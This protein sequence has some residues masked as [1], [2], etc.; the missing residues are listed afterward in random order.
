[1]FT[2]ILLALFTPVLLFAATAPMD[3]MAALNLLAYGGI[4]QMK[5]KIGGEPGGQAVNLDDSQWQIAYPGFQWNYPGTNIWL[6][7]HIAIPEKIG[8]FSLIGRKM[9]MYLYVDNGGDVFVNGDSLGTFKW[10]TATYT[11]SESL[12]PG[13]KFLIAIRGINGPGFGKIYDARIEF[14]GMVDFQRKLQDKVWG[15]LIARRLADQLSEK[16]S[17][18]MEELDQIAKR[19]VQSEAFKKGDE[20]KLLA[21]FDEEGKALQGLKDEMR[22]KYHLYCAGYAHIDLAWLWPWIETVEVV[23]STTQSVFNVMER[24]PQFKYSMGQAHAYQWLEEY[25]PDL[26]RQVKEKVNEG[27]WEIVGGMWVEPDCN[28]PSGESFVRQVLYGKRYFREKFGVDVKVCWIPD[29]FGFNWNLPQILVRSGFDAFV[30]HKINWNDTN[31]FPYRFFWWE[32]PDGSKLMSYIPRSGYGHDLNGDQLVDFIEEER[33]ELNFGKELVLYGVGNHGGGPTMQMLERAMLATQSPAFPELRLT[34]STDFFNSITA[35]EKAKL[36]KWDSEL[37]LEYHRGTYTTQANTKKHNRKGE[38]LINTAEKFASI[39]ALFGE[40]YPQK[41]FFHVWRTLLFNQFHD[42][43][44]G[45]S[46]NP[47][48]RDAEIEYSESEILSQDILD[49]SLATLAANIDT[50]GAG[51]ALIVFNQLS[52][53]RSGPVELA[54]DRLR[55][56]KEWSVL[57]ESGKPLPVQKIDANVLGAKLLFMAKDVPSMGYKVYRLMEKPSTVAGE[58]LSSSITSLRSAALDLKV[59]QASGLIAE[60]TDLTNNRSVLTQPRGNLLQLLPDDIHDAWDIKFTKPAIELDS[61]R[62]ISLIESG[63]V[64]ATIKVVHSYLGPQ[65]GKY[66][67]TEDFPSSF[68]TQHISLYAGLPYVE[69]RNHVMWW[70]QHKMLK[71][72]FPVNVYSKVAKYEIP[73]GQIERSTGF[74]T[75]FEK[76]RFEVPAQRWADVSD[77]QYGVSL[78]N[79]CKYGYDIKGNIMRLSLLRAPV[80]PDSMADRGYHDFR[81]ALYPHAGDAYQAG[82][83]RRGIEFNEPMRAILA[84]SHKGKLPKA[85]SFVQVAQDNIIVNS[86]KKAEDGPEWIV[87]VYEIAG[88]PARTKISFANDLTSVTEVNLIEDR[89]ASLQPLSNAFEVDIKPNEI[90]TFKVTLK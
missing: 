12:K 6:R 87:R 56:A 23:K 89:M 54:L 79:D 77:G 82:V 49:H 21:A 90:R 74:E 31:K 9:T 27:R 48:Y 45:S 70:E 43:L 18:W 61:A 50:R 42:I 35:E 38:E 68:F 46:I 5:Y 85:H 60:V 41:E 14:S 40:Q 83:V 36:P 84:P 78:I 65:K 2:R 15:L 37:Y 52:W 44:P 30:T 47:V 11:I 10:G 63:P 16:R 20:E 75:S 39:A 59:D 53:Q 17:V 4:G 34:T 76:A 26:F 1:M 62:E 22:S 19:I 57:D 28:L 69:V 13:D 29:S 7:S 64:R 58:P 73:Y 8:G 25:A 51:E 33:R 71:V 72:V 3:P 66:K 32:A 80:T 81:Y 67:P 24:F 88:K 86:I 55:A